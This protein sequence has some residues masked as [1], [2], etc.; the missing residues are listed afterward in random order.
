MSRRVNKRTERNADRHSTTSAPNHRFHRSHHQSAPHS[1]GVLD[2]TPQSILLRARYKPATQYKYTKAVLRFIRW[3]HRYYPSVE[4]RL[5]RFDELDRLL[6]RYF[7]HLRRSGRG[8]Q[9]ATFTYCGVI[10]IRRDAKGRLPFSMAALSGWR[11]LR[12]SRQHPPMTWPLACAVAHQLA[13]TGHTWVAVGTLLAFDCLLRVSELVAIRL[14]DVSDSVQV[15]PRLPRH[16]SITL[17]LTKS[18]RTQSVRII[19]RNVL[20]LFQRVVLTKAE[21]L[22][23]TLFPITA[24]QFRRR[25]KLACSQLGLSSRYVPHSLRHGGATMMYMFGTPAAD[26]KIRGRWK[27]LDTCERYIQSGEAMIGTIRAPE[28]AL[29]IGNI[30]ALDPVR[31]ISAAFKRHSRV[32]SSG[33]Q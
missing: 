26:I 30:V 24:A 10:M 22:N 23:D 15:D 12:P 1:D 2:A 7:E 29:R 5:Q 3:Q 17:P 27:E 32:E 6:H 31:F 4:R 16:T 18:G 20:K 9:Q 8:L 25:F 13:A 33:G 21:Q 19:D 28:T 11:L 14:R